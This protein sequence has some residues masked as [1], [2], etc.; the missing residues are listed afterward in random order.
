MLR[1]YSATSWPGSMRVTTGLAAL[2]AVPGSAAAIVLAGPAASFPARNLALGTVA[3]LA[4]LFHRP[5]AL[6]VAWPA[7]LPT[8]PPTRA[9]VVS[10]MAINVWIRWDGLRAVPGSPLTAHRKEDAMVSLC[11]CQS[12]AG[13]VERADVLER[14]LQFVS[15]T[16]LV[17]L[18]Q[19]F[20]M[21][22]P[23]VTFATPF[24]TS[25]WAATYAVG[26]VSPCL[27]A[28]QL[29]DRISTLYTLP[30]VRHQAKLARR[31]TV[32]SLS[33]LLD[34][35]RLAVD[36]G[37]VP[38][39]VRSSEETYIRLGR[40]LCGTWSAS[41]RFFPSLLKAI[42]A[43]QGAT[44]VLV[45]LLNGIAGCMTAW[46]LASLAHYVSYVGLSLLPLA[47]HNE[48]IGMVTDLYVHAQGK[49][50][51]LAL[52]ASSRAPALS[53]ELA[54]HDRVLGNLLDESRLFRAKFLGFG[55]DFGM[56][57]TLAATCVT[58][59]VALW[60][61]LRGVGLRA[62]LETFCPVVAD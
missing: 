36:T 26:L 48:S 58:L 50:R 55:V 37:C 33:N 30:Q 54:L 27:F 41:G 43:A 10:S 24:W 61:I 45:F 56:M 25:G 3:A 8:R 6:Y 52:D 42:F 40:A 34:R 13:D 39:T 23:A 18:V 38:D 62:T 9:D 49:L 59:G 5:L 53:A 7:L 51:S 44:M 1:T 47:A 31:A 22:T 17:F 60:G 20:L 2:L 21:W 4:V 32:L 35:Y 11:P 29:L 46:Q 12:C 57:R 28:L 16:V 14:Y 15:F 19:L